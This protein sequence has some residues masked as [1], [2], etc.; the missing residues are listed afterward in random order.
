[1]NV[2]DTIFW[3]IPAAAGAAFAAVGAAAVIMSPP[4]VAVADDDFA[5]A[6]IVLIAG[7]IAWAA[8]MRPLFGRREQAITLA[9]LCAIAVGWYGARLWGH[10][11]QAAFAAE[12]QNQQLRLNATQLS[13]TLIAFL[14]IREQLAP[15]RPAG[16]PTKNE[17]A[18]SQ[19]FEAETMRL[20]DGRFARDVRSTHDLLALRGLHDRDLDLI[21][22]RPANGFQIRIIADRMAMLASGLEQRP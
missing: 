14:R 2:R 10:Q 9:A 19:R 1:V 22:R 6:A 16:M 15:P 4:A 3:W 18:V 20:F 8:M 17:K 5:L 13:T 11:R 21:Y 7:V 12:R